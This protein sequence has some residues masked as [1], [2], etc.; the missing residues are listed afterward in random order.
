[1]AAAA[2][3]VK[4][5]ESAAKVYVKV[6]SRISQRCG[7]RHL[8]SE[9]VDFIGLRN[10]LVD[11]VYVAH[12]ANRY[13]QPSGFAGGLVQPLKV[14]VHTGAREIIEYMYSSVCFNKEVTGEIRSNESG[15]SNNQKRAGFL[16]FHSLA[17]SLI[18]LFLIR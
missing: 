17:F 15:A 12:I 13:L 1:M 9:V 16:S 8:G 7:Y 4:N 6:E 18:H 5:V 3:G 11:Q 2:R 10:C 14:V